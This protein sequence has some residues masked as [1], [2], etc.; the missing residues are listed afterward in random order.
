MKL[1]VYEWKKLLRLPALWVFLGLCLV[2]NLLLI[3]GLSLSDRAFFNETSA[4]AE[5]LGQ[6]VDQAFQDGLAAMPP[7]ENR[8][9]LRQSVSGME[10]IFETYDTDELTEFY[11]EIVKSSPLAQKW[12]I[13]KYD[14]LA[15]R[16]AHLAETD[17]ALD[18]Y[19]GPA[20]HGSHQ[21]LFG[22]LLRAVLCES[23]IIAMLGTLYLLGYEGMHRTEGLTYAARTGRRLRHIKV[24]AA[25]P[26][27]VALYLLLALVSLTP[28]FL[29]YDYS[30]IWKASVSSQF[31]YLTDLLFTRPFLTWG[32]LTVAQ[33]LLAF[34]ALGIGLTAV[35][36]LLAA[37]CGILVRN[38]YFAALAAGVLCFGGLGVTSVMG[39]AGL[40]APYLISNLQPTALWLS[41]SGWFTELGLNAVLP[42]QETVGVG[43]N[44]L[45]WGGG[46]ALALHRFERKDVA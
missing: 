41:C 24:L 5:A 17:A 31:N 44:L 1:A 22:T 34:L 4:T 26:V 28:Y 23:G 6:R 18:L 45:L 38:T 16:V 19:A 20:T 8:A 2:F 15:G 3:A 46:T 11:T 14:R 9:L 39:E 12:M 32:D 10:D 42:W 21:F 27:S 13:W 43:V 29:L 35:F 37:V 25:I 30:G 33:Y 40:W 7:T 36:S